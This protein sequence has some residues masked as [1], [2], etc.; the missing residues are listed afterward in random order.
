[1]LPTHCVPSC[2]RGGELHSWGW[3]DEQEKV[4]G[5]F[6]TLIRLCGHSERVPIWHR[7]SGSTVEATRTT[8]WR[9]FCHSSESVYLN[10]DVDAPCLRQDGAAAHREAEEV[11]CWLNTFMDALKV[12]HMVL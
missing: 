9:G 2:M 6:Y 8:A 10:G 4:R 11:M 7:V 3:N 1:M 5:T 12:V